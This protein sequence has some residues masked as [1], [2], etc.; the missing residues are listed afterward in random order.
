MID[1][2]KKRATS[3]AAMARWRERNPEKSRA[4]ARASMA[5][6]R[7]ANPARAMLRAAQYRAQQAGVPCTIT[8]QDIHIPDKCPVSG[9]GRSFND[10][11]DD[12][13]RNATP[14]LDKYDPRLGYIPGNVWVIC[15]TCNSFKRD[16]TGEEFVSYGMNLIQSFKEECERVAQLSAQG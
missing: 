5:K 4:N 14:S 1:I 15:F 8:E 10:N 11:S 16:L 13:K 9:C 2:E 7:A 12:S 3:R 6:W